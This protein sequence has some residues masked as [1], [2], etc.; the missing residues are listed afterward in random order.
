MTAESATATSTLEEQADRLAS[1]LVI[2]P[3]P[4]ILARFTSEMNQD[5]PDLRK[6]SGLIGAD[7]ALSA[8]ML[9]TVNSPYYGLSRKATSIQHALTILGLRASA[10]LITRL[11]LRHAFPATSGS[12]MQ[13]FWDASLEMTDTAAQLCSEFRSIDRDEVQTY[14]L[15]RD[16]GMAVMIAKFEDYGAVLARHEDSPGAALLMA[17]DARYRYNH[18]RVGY[19]L[20]RGWFLPEPMCK[21]ILFHHDIERAAAGQRDAVPADPK[22]VAFG[23]LAEQIAALRSNR[24]LCPDWSSSEATV[25]RI[26]QL[27]P[28]QIVAMVNPESLA[29]A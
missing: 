25:L 10:N 13:R 4:A 16:C 15:F 5:D 22:L 23:L 24:G 7:A 14:A 21:A 20:A 11:L 27:D 18:A 9:G 17:E 26:L 1:D 12:L 6:L 28:E 29:A 8:A 19:A 3:C 2:P